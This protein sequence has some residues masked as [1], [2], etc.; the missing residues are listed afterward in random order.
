MTSKHTIMLFS[1][2]PPLKPLHMVQGTSL[3]LQVQCV[4]IA[5]KV[6][7]GNSSP[8]PCITC[9]ATLHK[10]CLKP[11]ICPPKNSLKRS[12]AD[13]TAFDSDDEDP[14]VTESTGLQQ[15]RESS[16]CSVARQYVPLSVAPQLQ[17][18]IDASVHV[19]SV[20]NMAP[21][22][23]YSTTSTT[24]TSLTFSSATSGNLLPAITFSSI[25]SSTECPS[26]A[27]FVPP[28]SG[29]TA[30]KPASKKS[31]TAQISPESVQIEYLKKEIV[32]A[33]TKITSL[34]SQIRAKD[35]SIRILN[36]RISA[37]ENPIMAQFFSQY[38][39]SNPSVSSSSSVPVPTSVS[40]ASQADN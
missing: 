15:V 12:A 8:V 18:V 27:S 21:S 29:P 3:P 31:K 1:F 26:F 24:T 28:A 5:A 33:Q 39:P 23:S 32:I 19:T 6:F 17:A 25:Q 36:D 7:K 9:P 34:E 2:Y 35:D 11:H 16:S 22:C 13:I 37:T 20:P 38:F 30:R 40:T 14:I 4:T 10:S